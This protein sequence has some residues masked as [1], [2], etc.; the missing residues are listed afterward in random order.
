MK[1]CN[2]GFTLIELLIVVAIIGILAAIA[3]PNFLNAQIRAQVGRVFADLKNLSIACESYYLDNNSYPGG[4]KAWVGG[5]PF[6]QK[7]SYRFHPLTTPIAY[8][9]SV[10]RDPFQE[11]LPPNLGNTIWD[12]AYVY[13]D[14]GLNNQPTLY[15]DSCKYIIQS[16]GPDR[17]WE[18][19]GG[20]YAPDRWFAMS[21]GLRSKGDIVYAGPGGIFF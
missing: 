18:S 13:H 14:I 7:H 3:V 6:W 5:M 2:K 8:I 1:H 20:A 9:S 16:W 21:N 11:P 10:P 12:G 19:H 4:P 17:S 15:C